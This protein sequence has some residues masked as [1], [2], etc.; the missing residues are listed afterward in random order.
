MILLEKKKEDTT[1]INSLI[2]KVSGAGDAVSIVGRQTNIAKTGA[3]FNTIFSKIVD[4]MQN[5]GRITQKELGQLL[6]VYKKQKG[7]TLQTFAKYF[8]FQKFSLI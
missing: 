4:T 7:E 3:E 8:S 6:N 5:K 1:K 2:N